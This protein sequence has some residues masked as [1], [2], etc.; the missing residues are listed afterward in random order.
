[1]A[2]KQLF[3]YAN[4]NGHEDF[5]DYYEYKR[6]KRNLIRYLQGKKVVIITKFDKLIWTK[7]QP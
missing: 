3:Y 2:R 4:F 6:F 1:M 5:L 7:P